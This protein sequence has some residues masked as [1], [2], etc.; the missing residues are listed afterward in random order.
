MASYVAQQEHDMSGDFV[1][2]SVYKSG[3][4][5]KA[6][7]FPLFAIADDAAYRLALHDPE[8]LLRQHPDQ[9]LQL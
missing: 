4:V 6:G 2:W 3:G 9:N 1:G 7:P 5:R 8:S